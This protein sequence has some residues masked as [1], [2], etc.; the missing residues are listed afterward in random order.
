MG[1][2]SDAEI[3]DAV[4][5]DPS[6]VQSRSHEDSGSDRHRSQQRLGERCLKHTNSMDRGICIETVVIQSW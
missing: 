1:E 2:E 3:V 5:E 4:C 6:R